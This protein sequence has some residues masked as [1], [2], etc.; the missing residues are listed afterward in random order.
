MGFVEAVAALVGVLVVL[1]LGCYQVIFRRPLPRLSGTLTVDGLQGPVEIR[2]DRT[3]VPHVRAQSRADG[4]FAVGFLHAQDRMWQMELHRRIAAGRLSEVVGQQAIPVDQLMRKLGLRR[5]SEAEWH[6]TQAAGELRSLLEAYTAGVNAA[7]RDRPLAAEFTI[8]RHR[9]EPWEPEDCLAVGRLLSFTQS[10]NWEAQLIRMR[11]LKELGPELTA[12]IDPA[13]PAANPW[14]DTGLPAGEWESALLEQLSAV[15]ELLQLSTWASASNTWVV[16]GSRSATGK[17]LL[18][19]DPHGTLTTP[20]SWHQVHLMTPEDEIA[21]LAFLGTPFIAFGH[22][23][24]IAWG[25]VNAQL[26]T[27]SLYVERL[28]PNNPLQ[29][30]DRGAWQDAVRFREVIRVRGSEP[31]LEDVLVT[32]HGPVISSAVPGGQPPISLRWVGLDSELDSL[33]WAMR[34][35]QARDWKGFRF[36]VGSCPAPAMGMSYAD[37]E[38]NIGFRLM[39]FIP[40][41]P[42]GQGRLPVP[43]WDGSGEWLGFIPFEEVPEAFNPASGFIVAA[44]NPIAYD[45]YPLVFEPTT[46]YRARRVRDSVGANPALSVE[47]CVAL[48]NDVESLPGGALRDI[49]LERLEGDQ[50]ESISLAVGLLA[51]WDARLDSDSSGGCVYEG[52][53]ERL[54]DR[55]IGSRLSPSL[56][57]QVL[58]RSVH[59][60]FPIGP[61]SGRL[62]PSIIEAVAQ[63]RPAPGSPVDHERCDQLLAA[64]LAETVADLRR[65]QGSDPAGWRWGAEQQVVY[66]HPVADAVRPLAAILNRGPFAGSGDTDTVRLMGH[67]AGRGILSPTTAA[68]CRAVYDLGDWKRSVISHSPGQSGHPA[69]PHYAD[70]IEEYLAGRPC[71]L[72]F[73]PGSFDADA[74]DDGALT[75]RPRA[76]DNPAANQ[77][78]SG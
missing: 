47:D 4:A 76:A 2:R 42:D 11:M 7:M 52:L 6:V 71:P 44:N 5:V 55:M 64:C 57:D 35:N 27:Q 37:T 63:G 28:N 53:L 46:G 38:G 66:A 49:V 60:F 34:L 43:G 20:S 33:G 70:M 23:Q 24:R 77:L 78:G 26:S 13:Y 1:V 21:G 68:T 69:S 17:A 31:V 8:L 58:A 12:A 75:L 25:I 73:G 61:F 16:D 40:L 65:R 15:D 30:E 72:D 39:G 41:R 56:R 59:P 67:S 54:A 48:Q 32:R 10:G 29:F 74:G 45:R 18:A 62:T 51:A 14:V 19:N 3:G 50:D 36:A 9:P 22:N